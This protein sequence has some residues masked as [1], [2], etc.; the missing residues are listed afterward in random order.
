MYLGELAALAAAALWGF[1]SVFLFTPAAERIGA[2]R[3]NLFRLPL[4]F[5]LLSATLWVRQQPVAATPRG[6]GLLAVSGIVGLSLGDSFYFAGL[7]R[8]GP[9]LTVLLQALAP[10]FATAFG[11][12]LLREVPGPRALLG[13]ALTMGGV[14]WVVSEKNAEPHHL[15]QITPGVLFALAAAACQGLGLTLSKWGMQEGVDPWA[16]SWVRM[17]V[18]TCFLWLAVLLSKPR[19]GVREAWGKAGGQL[20]AGAVFGP[21]LGAS[22]S[23]VAAQR[24]EVGVAATLMATTPILVIPLVM[25]AHRYRPTIRAVLGT[26]LAVAGVGL[27]FSR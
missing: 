10:L 24:V 1:T 18:A 12:L 20:V 22:L 21:F 17:G 5:L 19:I 8:L 13:T 11:Y 3:V 9:R 6:L 27:L 16:A 25:L 14:A 7:R 23:L 4:A 26:L 15:G 2:L